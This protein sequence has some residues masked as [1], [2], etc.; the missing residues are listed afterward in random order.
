M[1]NHT[2]LIQKFRF[3]AIPLLAFIALTSFRGVPAVDLDVPYEP[4]H[5][6]VVD[7]MLD[8]AKV[9]KQ[10]VL[11]DLGCGDGRIPIRAARKFGARGV[12]IDLD[13][14]RIDEAR[15]KARDFGVAEKI[16]FVAGDALKADLRDATVVTLYLLNSIN[17][18]LRPRLFEQLQPGTRVVSHAF[19][20]GE[21]KPDRKLTHRKARKQTIYYWIMP[22]KVE[23]TWNWVT[24]TDA[25][26]PIKNYI[27]FKRK[28][29]ELS[30]RVNFPNSNAEIVSAFMNGKRI[31]FETRVTHNGK[32][33]HIKYRG[34]VRGNLIVG[35][36][37]WRNW[38]GK[39]IGAYT[40]RARREVSRP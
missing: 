36:Q 16:R 30:G 1:R 10:D 26:K 8:L 34:I 24:E 6:R 20:M 14:E 39:W 15:E 9:Q 5:P 2:A 38:T 4:S 27:K 23:G 40:W 21:W 11:Y 32:R 17:K 29:Q 3:T 18:R 22:E 25:G 19:H 13:K 28:Y 37:Y 35:K 12:C 7:A 33:L 31:R